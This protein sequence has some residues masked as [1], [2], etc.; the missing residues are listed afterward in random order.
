MFSHREREPNTRMT[1]TDTSVVGSAAAQVAAP[2]PNLSFRLARFVSDILSPPILTLPVLV[3]AAMAADAPD[4]WRHVALYALVAVLVPVVDLAWQ[5]HS[6]RITDIHL[7]ERSERIRSFAVGTI[8]GSVGLVLLVAVAASPIVVAFAVMALAQAVVLFA[9][10]LRWQV[11]VHGAAAASLAVVGT[12]L[13][14]SAA[15]PLWLLVPLV[16]WSRLRLNRHTPAQ[17]VVGVGVGVF[18]PMVVLGLLLG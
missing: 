6:G 2:A 11:S 4:A 1:A 16:T 8:A 15:A 10:T 3:M 18:L 12:F 7:P 9:I 14:G 17:M 13:Y 5:L